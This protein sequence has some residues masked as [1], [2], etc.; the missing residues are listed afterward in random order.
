MTITLESGG[1]VDEGGRRYTCDSVQGCQIVGR[2]VTAGRI[3]ETAAP[4]GG[5]LGLVVESVAADVARPM[6]GEA[7]TLSATVRNRG[8]LPAAATTLRYFQSMDTMISSRDRRI[9]SDPVDALAAAATQELSYTFPAPSLAG[10]YYYGACVEVVA[11][12]V[13]SQKCSVAVPVTVPIDLGGVAE[14]FALHDDNRH[15]AGIAYANDR[16]YVLDDFDDRIYAYNATSSQQEPLAEFDLDADNGD[17]RAM[18]YADGS[19]YVVDGTEDKVYAYLESGER[20]ADADV[21]LYD[22]NASPWAIERVG[23]KL[24]VADVVD[25]KVYAY[26][27]TGERDA[28][29]DFFLDPDNDS[30]WG[31]AY[32][33]HRFFVADVVDDKVY[34]YDTEGR[35]HETFDFDLH[36]DNRSPEGIAF[37]ADRFY[38]ADYFDDTVYGYPFPDAPDLVV[39]PPAVS[40]PMPVPGASLTATATLRNAGQVE[41]GG[42]L[43]K[44]YL[45]TDAA[46]A[47]PESLLETTTANALAP[48]GTDVVTI[49]MTAP[50]DDGCYL[51]GVCV[52]AVEGER[53]STNNCSV[54]TE[55]QIGGSPELDFSRFLLRNPAS[56]G[57]PVELIVGVINRG[58]VRSGPA[59]VR[60]SDGAEVVADVP[61]LDPGESVILDTLDL[62]A[63]KSG[64]TT[65]EVCISDVP[66]EDNTEN[67]CRSRVISY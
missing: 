16:L 36:A 7:L 13:A 65:Y 9:G 25:R 23:G 35:R 51:C 22:L 20:D 59:K 53:S 29:A 54:P 31:M 6:A 32:V 67:N 26:L 30:P 17:P 43:L 63:A 14:G 11:D 66:C 15:P 39:D 33:E 52:D 58:D 27:A 3:I 5:G 57:Q 46:Y 1:H 61:A 2:E 34:A 42:T 10:F 55:I 40:D 56:V 38:V 48:G 44:F 64:S 21:E 50:D 37:A 12:G 49:D 45:S 8:D 28:D 24:F 19:F 18:A 62:G 60:V 4:T 47:K 41:S